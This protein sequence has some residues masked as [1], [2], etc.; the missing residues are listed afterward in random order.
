MSDSSGYR[1]EIDGLR[2]IAVLA[3]LFY[4]AGLGFPGGFLGVDV[5]FV[6]SGYLITDLLTR[7][8][9]RGSF[10]LLEFWER[11]V[12]RLIPALAVLT[13]T[14]ALIS[15]FILLPSDLKHLGGALLA[16]P[17]LVANIYFH[18]TM[19]QGY[20]GVS[21]S[22]FPM[23]HTWSLAVEEQFYLFY[24]LIIVLLFRFLQTPQRVNKALVLLTA[25]SFGCSV[26]MASVDKDSAFF[27][28]GPRAWE[29]LLGGIVALAPR[30]SGARGVREIVGWLGLAMIIWSILRDPASDF[31][32]SVLFWP[33][34]GTALAIWSNGSG[35]STTGRLLAWTPLVAIGLI[36]YSLYLWHGPIFAFADYLGLNYLVGLRVMLVFLSIGFATASYFFVETPFRRKRLLSSR[37]AIF[38]LGGGYALVTA[39]A[40][41][42]FYFADGLPQNWTERALSMEHTRRMVE[43]TFPFVEPDAPNP[44]KL[45]DLDRHRTSFLVFGDSHAG[46]LAPAFDA[47]AKER[48]LQGLLACRPGSLPLFEPASEEK[49]P[50]RDYVLG[51]VRDEEVKEV[52][53]V[54]R[55]SVHEPFLTGELD[56]FVSDMR[57]AGAQV[58]LVADVPEQPVVT[59]RLLALATR[60]KG[61]RVPHASLA[62]HRAKNAWIDELFLQHQAKFPGLRIV[63][64]APTVA[65]W[66]GLALD[67]QPVYLDRDHLSRFGALKV[68][69]L[70][71]SL[72]DEFQR[73]EDVRSTRGRK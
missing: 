22:E 18:K 53:I 3:V 4:H 68:A 34:L 51:L 1:P 25:L 36:S 50:W 23:L 56:E 62:D 15:Y 52:L 35:M 57:S 13:F 66:E 45:G 73:S 47:L 38:M 21:A 31:F 11:R 59:T 33:C 54:A 8:V 60:F 19:G 61:L 44:P 37:G 46:A 20:F 48:A 72:F 55:W 49:R 30:P 67:G 63:D 28:L 27:W 70:F 41:A 40:G 17:L 14:V 39:C 58:T 7:S 69:P 42:F 5:F 12:R 29:L 71:Q 32:T 6:I 9:R 64:P 24:P 65:S 43:E 26:S 16:Q 2:A 10:S